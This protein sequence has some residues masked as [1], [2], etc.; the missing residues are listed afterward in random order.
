MSNEWIKCSERL[1]TKDI[2]VLVFI[3]QGNELGLRTLG[4]YHNGWF[5]GAKNE[6]NKFK[7]NVTHWQSLPTPPE[8]S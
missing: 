8:N 3:P 7:N 6:A 1:P 4:Y 5:F 2:V